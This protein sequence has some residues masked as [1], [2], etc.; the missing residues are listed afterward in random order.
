MTV[1]DLKITVWRVLM[2]SNHQHE[3]CLEE[4][5]ENWECGQ[6]LEESTQFTPP[7]CMRTL[8]REGINEGP[9]GRTR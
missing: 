6:T 8:K 3:K 7:A 5:E 4:Y 1:E 9:A 2:V